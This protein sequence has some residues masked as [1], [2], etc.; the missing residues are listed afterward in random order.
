MKQ[1]SILR[2][3]AAMGVAAVGCTL[4]GYIGGHTACVHQH[5]ST[6]EQDKLLRDENGNL[7]EKRYLIE[8]FKDFVKMKKDPLGLNKTLS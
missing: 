5:V 7:S 6:S 4:G 8:A 3:F 1:V 2:A